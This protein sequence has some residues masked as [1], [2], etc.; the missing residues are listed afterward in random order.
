[1]FAAASA[2]ARPSRPS[3]FRSCAGCARST[4]ICAQCRHNA[5]TVETSNDLFNEVLCRSMADLYMLMTKTPQ[6][7]Y[8]YAGI[9]WYSTTF[10]R[11]GLIT[12]LQMLWLDPRIARACC[13]ASP[14]SRPRDR[15]SAL[16]RASPERSC[17]RCASGEMAALREVPFGLYYG[18]VDATPLFVMLA[19]LYAERTGDD[20]T[21]RGVVARHRG[22]ARLDRRP[23]R[24]RRRRL[25]RIL[26]RDR[27]GPRQ[28][29]LEG[30]A[31]RDLPRRRTAGGGPDRARGGAGLRLQ[32]QAPGGA[33]RASG[34]AACSDARPRSRPR[35]S[36]WPSDSTPRSGVLSSAPTRSRSTARSSPVA[37]AAPM[38]GR[39]CSPASRGRSGR[40]RSA[41]DCCG[42]IS[43]PAGASAPSPIPRA[44]YNPMS[45]H[46]GSIWP[47]D[48]ALIALGLAR[49]GLQAFG[50]AR[51]QGP[52]RRRHL[53][54]DAP[55][56]GIVLRLPARPRPRPDA[57]PRRLLAAGL[58]QRHA[59]HADRGLARPAVRSRRERNPPAQSA[60]CRRSWTKWCCATC[61]SRTRAS[62]SRCAATPTTSRSKFSSGAAISRSR[63]SSAATPA[64]TRAD[65][66]SARKNNLYGASGDNNLTT[67]G[68]RP[69]QD[70]DRDPDRAPASGRGAGAGV[71]R[72]LRARRRHRRCLRRARSGPSRPQGRAGRRPARARRPGRQLHHR[73]VLRVVRQRHRT[74]S[75]SPTASPTTSCASSAR[76]ARCTTAAADHPTPRW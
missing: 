49:Y 35:P 66:S 34:L 63:S 76:R 74:A 59:L 14:R 22:R 65:R 16:R 45:Y 5:A 25:H 10:G 8:P 62:T 2:A 51:V 21:H 27:G 17:T 37:C 15:R 4:A 3:R 31:G 48:N 18:T 47:H 46:N 38:P 32:R 33:L 53:H 57:L 9:P 7:P 55:A 60:A 19:G 6:G 20:A 28:P 72:Y 70:P 24:S 56:A 40:S 36:S 26:P 42:R 67:D 54:G 39:C 11:D 12:A 73:H 58:G 1:M 43:S 64:P 61:T 23:R 71:G 44:R 13:G 41:T 75:S 52:V 68:L 29:G 50:R 30:F 69:G